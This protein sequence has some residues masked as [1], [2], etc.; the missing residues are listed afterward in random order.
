[1]KSVLKSC[2]I[3][4]PACGREWRL[5]KADMEQLWETMT[6]FDT[7]DERLPYWAE[8]WP[9]SL[10]LAEWLGQHAAALRG[11]ACL[12]IGCGLGFTALVGQWLGGRVLGMDYE[13]E[14]LCFA[15]RNA[16]NNDLHPAWAVMDWRRPAVR[17]GSM[18]FVWGGDIMYERRF[19]APLADFLA[20]TLAPGGVAWVAEP[21]R[22][23]YE[24]FV[25][26]VATRGFGM[27]CIHRVEVRPLTPQERPVPV[28][29][30]QIM[31]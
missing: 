25:A 13:P 1:M 18:H 10:A 21:S 11:R 8:L 24:A 23:V 30:W 6:D 26:E 16:R 7:D 4:A 28:R 17:Q 2:E 14:A 5:E 15:I 20:H 19:A 3:V 31:R 22:T 27:K 29:I 9:S 12:D